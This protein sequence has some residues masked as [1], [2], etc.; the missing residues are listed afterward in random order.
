MATEPVS[1]IVP[2]YKEAENIPILT[3]RLF[4]AFDKAGIPG[5]LILIDDDS[6]D[7]TEAV[8]HR[9]AED[10]TVRLITR[11]GERGL[12]SAVLRG[13]EEARHD[14]LLCMDADL[15]HPPESVPDILRPVAENRSEFCIG[16]RYAP[17]GVTK[18]DWG[19]L[20]RINS[21]GATWLARPLTRA[22]DPMA[23]FFC[24]RRTTLERARAAGLNPIGYKIALEIIVK[25]HCRDVVEVPIVFTD[26]LHG[27]SK[28]TF[29][30]QLLYLGHL[31]RLY[32]FRWPVAAP[33]VA[34]IVAATL[35]ILPF[36][37]IL[38]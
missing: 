24:L 4:A 14:L 26:R 12:S 21:R 15:S 23:G 6:R 31:V 10:H 32:R 22:R 36:W 16:S 3:E 17:G 27:E 13:F 30:Q 28:L 5:E 7:G 20:R 1:I 19:L 35:L 8:A 29:H 34:L 38:T 37:L 33:L 11:T 2:T 25:A 18:D 9:L